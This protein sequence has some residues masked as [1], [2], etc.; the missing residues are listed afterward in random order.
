MVHVNVAVAAAA[1]PV[2]V[3]VGEVSSVIIPV[4]AIVHKPVSGGVT[5]FP[6][7]VAVVTPQA[8]LIS[9]PAAATVGVAFT[10]TEAVLAAT[11]PH[12]LLAAKV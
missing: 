11:E 5:A 3:E 1:N 9:V 12:V 10:V 7:K 8:G 6:A 2:T 4:P